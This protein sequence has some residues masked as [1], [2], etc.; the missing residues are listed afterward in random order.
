[1]GTP[2]SRTVAPA[3]PSTRSRRIH[4]AWWIAA[5]TFLALFG[6]AGFRGAP[7]ALMV[8]LHDEF[9]WSM[10]AMSLAVGLNLVLYGLVA[11]FAAAP[12]ERFGIRRVVS[13]ALALVALGAIGS[14][15][16]TA[17]WQL[18]VFWGLLI[19]GAPDP[20]RS[21]SPRRSPTAGSSPSEDSSWACSLRGRRPANW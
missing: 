2:P 13:T 7:G 21:C 1:M 19:G 10:S 9:G 20:W 11:P 16:M 4:P 8:P 15:G 18:L 3:G 5:V 17:S 14:V 6:A 12:M